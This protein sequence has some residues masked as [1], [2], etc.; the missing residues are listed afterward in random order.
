MKKIVVFEEYG[1]AFWLEGDKVFNAPLNSD[2]SISMEEA[3]EVE[4]WDDTDEQKIRAK[5]A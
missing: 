4:V 3:G 1:S 2:G 5:L